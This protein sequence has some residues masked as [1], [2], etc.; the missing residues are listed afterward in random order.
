MNRIGEGLFLVGLGSAVFFGWWNGW[1]ALLI[2]DATTRVRGSAGPSSAGITPLTPVER[3]G[4]LNRVDAAR[5]V[6]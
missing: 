6:Q 4:I 2:E 5:G 1:F 3:G